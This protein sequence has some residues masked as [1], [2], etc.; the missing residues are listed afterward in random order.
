[1]AEI[2]SAVNETGCCWV[3]LVIRF[4]KR[5]SGWTVAADVRG[6]DELAESKLSL[7]IVSSLRNS[8]VD[9]GSGWYRNE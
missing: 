1:M 9:N 7:V 6:G 4:A 2:S 3:T 5:I 8:V